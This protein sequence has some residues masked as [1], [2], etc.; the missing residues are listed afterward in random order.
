[1]EWDEGRRGVEL[2]DLQADPRESKNV[3]KAPEHVAVVAEL[4]RPLRGRIVSS[5]WRGLAPG[6]A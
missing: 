5:H 1:M 6:L 4:K 3:A 2:Y